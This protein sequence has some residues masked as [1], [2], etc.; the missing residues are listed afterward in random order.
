ML[1]LDG[2]EDNGDCDDV[3]LWVIVKDF[4][5]AVAGFPWSCLVC[6]VP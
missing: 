1:P 6:V 4:A 2:V 5:H 3:M